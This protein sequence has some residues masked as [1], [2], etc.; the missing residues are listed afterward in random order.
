[1]WKSF[2]RV[3]NPIYMDRIS[4]LTGK[5]DDDP[6]GAS[7]ARRAMG[8]TRRLAERLDLAAMTPRDDCASTKYCLAQPGEAYVVYLPAGSEATVDLTAAEGVL[9]VEWI[10]PVNGTAEKAA[11][12]EGGALRTFRSPLDGD[13]VLYLRRK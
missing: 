6:A 1:M 4:V 13:A 3:H 2:L 7:G 9:E 12:I 8:H 11:P 10:D 5:P